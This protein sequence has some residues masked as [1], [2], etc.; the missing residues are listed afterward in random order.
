MCSQPP[1]IFLDPSPGL[2]MWSVFL[3]C[4][5]STFDYL[6]IR[7][8]AQPSFFICLSANTKQKLLFSCSSW[9]EL[10]LPYLGGRNCTGVLPKSLNTF[11]WTPE[12]G[13]TGTKEAQEL[14]RDVLH[15]IWSSRRS[16]CC[17]F[18]C[19]G[20]S[21]AAR[22]VPELCRAASQRGHFKLLCSVGWLRTEAPPCVWC[23][24]RRGVV[25]SSHA[26]WTLRILEMSLL[27]C[28]SSSVCRRKSSSWSCADVS[29][30]VT[31]CRCPFYC[32]DVVLSGTS[33]AVQNR[34]DFIYFCLSV[35]L[36]SVCIAA[37]D[38]IKNVQYEKLQYGDEGQI[39]Q[40]GQG[41]NPV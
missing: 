34:T 9:K 14:R 6:I 13:S 21:T 17:Q 33:R 8:P 20:S 10:K 19:K 23:I 39:L 37:P 41:H 36:A 11:F 16:L 26:G 22:R 18:G 27:V 25:G 28:K 30:Y 29:T 1:V 32:T 24:W 4:L 31:T 35:H 7:V 3:Q 12:M 15:L 5:S 38:T 2:Q 40:P